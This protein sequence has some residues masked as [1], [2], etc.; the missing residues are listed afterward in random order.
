MNELGIRS[1]WMKRKALKIEP[2]DNIFC[3][4][5]DAV[6]ISQFNEMSM[7]NVS[8][9]CLAVERNSKAY[10]TL[11]TERRIHQKEIENVQRVEQ[12]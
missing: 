11:S 7:F 3:T 4:F 6:P 2:L 12:R 1:K 5:S 9:F 10:H 8:S